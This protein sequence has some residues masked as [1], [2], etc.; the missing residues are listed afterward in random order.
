MQ[1]TYYIF[2]RISEE[3]YIDSLQKKGHIYCNTIRYFRS[4]E[5]NR[6]RGDNN[7]G[8]AFIKQAKNL[9]VSLK[10][11]IIGKAE[12]AQIY[13]DDDKDIGNIFCIYGVKTSLIDQLKKSRQRVLIEKESKDFGKTALLI[14]N[15]QEFINRISESLLALRKVFK[16]A[17]VYYFDPNTYQGKLNPFYKSDIYKHQ[18]EVRLWIQNT[19]EKPF[20]FYI[21]DISDIS[22][23][24]PVSDLDK[25]EVETL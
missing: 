14:F 2:I 15:I 3:K 12:N 25:I 24:I 9:E 22:H 13:F 1:K 7:E 17:P 21:G 19:E 18:N 4:I 11:K 23:K 10:G 8:K 5:D 16:I 20:E 6:N